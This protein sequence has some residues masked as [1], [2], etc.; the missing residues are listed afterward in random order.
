[1]K[2]YEVVQGNAVSQENIWPD[3]VN[4]SRHKNSLP[5]RSLHLEANTV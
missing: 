5:L 2:H 4:K 3:G 1:M